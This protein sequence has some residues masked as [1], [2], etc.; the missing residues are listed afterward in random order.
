MAERVKGIY[1]TAGSSRA[2]MIALTE[3]NVAVNSGRQL[4]ME[5]AGV[6][7]KGWLTSHLENTRATHTANEIHSE[8]YNGIEIDDIWPNGCAYPGDPDGE[9][10]ETINCR[11]VGYA[12]KGEKSFKP[13][14]FLNFAEFCMRCNKEAKP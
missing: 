1:N 14:K 12:I 10:G 6:E 8:T 9:A 2:A 3:T 5:Q 11:C 4:A 13:V 7:R